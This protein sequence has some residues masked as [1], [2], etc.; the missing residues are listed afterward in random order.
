M[1]IL[2]RSLR[3]GVVFG[4]ILAL[5][6]AT[7]LRSTPAPPVDGSQ[8]PPPVVTAI[9]SD[10][11]ALINVDNTLED[12]RFVTWTSS[13]GLQT[14]LYV[15]LTTEDGSPDLR[16]ASSLEIA[17]ASVCGPPGVQPT[18]SLT[19]TRSIADPQTKFGIVALLLPDDFEG[20]EWTIGA[21]PSPSRVATASQTAV[22]I[23]EAT[24][25]DEAATNGTIHIECECG[26]FTINPGF[27]VR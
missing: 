19:L 25:W 16:S 23:Y 13:V 24:D 27:E 9:D 7:F 17:V 15:A 12:D 4:V 18:D 3:A 5:A 21:T 26:T 14:C 11:N 22:F 10:R 1:E 20:L 8:L 6:A 2:D